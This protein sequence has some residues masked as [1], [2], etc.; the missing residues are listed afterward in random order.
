M[1]RLV[2]SLSFVVLGMTGGAKPAAATSV[3]CE[4]YCLT[5]ASFCYASVGWFIGR[6]KC[7]AFYEGC[8]AGCQAA[9]AEKMLQEGQ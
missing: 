8:V 4:A 6:D 2:L 7:D 3:A 1:R 9:A 5:A